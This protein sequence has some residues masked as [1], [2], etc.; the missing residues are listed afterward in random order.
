M[1]NDF[2]KEWFEQPP[3]WNAQDI[4]TADIKRD[5]EIEVHVAEGKIEQQATDKVN[6]VGV[7]EPCVWPF[8]PG[9]RHVLPILHIL[10]GLGN[11]IMNNFW[12]FIQ[13]QIEKFPDEVIQAQNT[14]VISCL[15]LEK[16]TATCDAACSELESVAEERLTFNKNNKR[17]LNENQKQCKNN[18]KIKEKELCVKR[19]HLEEAKKNMKKKHDVN[20]K[21]EGE[22]VKK[23]GKVC[24]VKN[25]IERNMLTCYEVFTTRCHGGDLE[26]NSVPNFMKSGDNVFEK[27]F[28]YL[29]GKM[30]KV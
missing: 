19:N 2:D 12:E 10:L 8:I 24:F 27:T 5:L 28:D 14:S 23:H 25:V 21:S 3:L 9:N 15:A 11:K 16:V 18:L 1:S 17:K 6:S 22:V 26:G 20:N 7:K 13:D 4:V 30:K 29:I